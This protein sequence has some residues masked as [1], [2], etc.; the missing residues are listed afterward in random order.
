MRNQELRGN[1]HSLPG[2]GDLAQSIESTEPL[3]EPSKP[4]V[5]KITH[6]C[7]TTLRGVFKKDHD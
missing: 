1:K 3:I 6:G 7:V 2:G 4:S 5:W